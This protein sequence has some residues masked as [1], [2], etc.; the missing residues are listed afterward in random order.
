MADHISEDMQSTIDLP[1]EPSAE[2]GIERSLAERLRPR[3]RVEEKYARAGGKIKTK[4]FFRRHEKRVF[5]PLIKAGL[6]LLGLYNRGQRHALSPIILEYDL[7]FPDLPRAFEGFRLLHLADLHIDS[8]V[9]L[10]EAL[11]PLLHSIHADL[12]VITGDFGF[13]DEGPW[14][15]VYRCLRK[16]LPSIAARHGIYGILGNHDQSPIAFELESLGVRMLINEAVEVRQGRESI[17]L[18]GIDDPFDYKCDDLPGALANI[19]RD[20][21]KV[22][23]AHTPDLYRDAADSG[24]HLYLCGHTHGGQVRIPGIGALRSN[25]KCPRRYTYRRW[26][27]KGMEG[28]TGG[29]I[30]CSSL[31]I[32]LNCPPEIVVFTLRRS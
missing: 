21:F 18:A 16:L 20:A 32:R 29:G 31:P 24:V 3:I 25:A 5:T 19:P 12:C 30:G 7:C 15:E 27:Y 6:Q 10:T 9:G 1:H 11:R 17:W 4:S 2:K 8:V 13:D 14:G 22:L 26:T 28:Y 23:L